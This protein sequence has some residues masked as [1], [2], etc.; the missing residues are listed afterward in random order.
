MGS[1]P[2]SRS[3]S[4]FSALAVERDAVKDF[5]E[6]DAAAAERLAREFRGVFNNIPRVKTL[7]WTRWY[8]SHL[9]EWLWS[10]APKGILGL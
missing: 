6:A 8:Y 5:R 4:I 9:W 3:S 2:R 7:M 1:G 10:M